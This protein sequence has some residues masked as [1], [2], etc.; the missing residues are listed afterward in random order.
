MWDGNFKGVWHN[1]STAGTESTSNAVNLTNHGVAVTSGVIGSAMQYTIAGP[2]YQDAA[3]TPTGVTDDNFTLSTWVYPTNNTTDLQ[4]PVY[5]G[6]WFSGWGIGIRNDGDWY[7]FMNNVT[8]FDSGAAVTL[9]TWQYLVLQR[10]GGTSTLYVNNVAAPN[11]TTATPNPFCCGSYLSIGGEANTI[12]FYYDGRVDETHIS[13]SVRSA[14]W[15]T[16]ELNDQKAGS[17]FVTV[18]SE[19]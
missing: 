2:N 12:N 11:T 16:C 15:L 13:Q 17:T 9:N 1:N 6:S 8:A 5:S 19:I 4:S 14:D 3:T 7:I 18:G 10:S